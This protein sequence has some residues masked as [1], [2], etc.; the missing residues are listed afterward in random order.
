VPVF[1]CSITEYAKYE[2]EMLCIL[3]DNLKHN[4]RS[5]VPFPSDVYMTL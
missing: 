5:L 4:G 2:K 1:L 3:A